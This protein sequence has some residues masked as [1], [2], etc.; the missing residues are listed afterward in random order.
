MEDTK[1]ELGKRAVH[2][3]TTADRLHRA[4]AETA[5]QECGLHRSQLLIMMYLAGCQTP[6]T[7]TNIARAFE[8]SSA[9]I[10]VTLQ[11]MERHGLITR[12]QQE[13]NARANRIC[14]TSEGEALLSRS[15]EYYSSVDE[16]MCRDIPEEDLETLIR[17][18]SKIQDNLRKEYPEIDRLNFLR[19]KKG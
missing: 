14:L 9:A 8:V 7:Q 11:K 10:T 2:L 13:G 19:E 12:E 4:A 5:M 15:K 3:F 1:R 16:C 6:P 17:I 18:L